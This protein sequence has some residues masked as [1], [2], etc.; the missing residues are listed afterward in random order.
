MGKQKFLPTHQIKQRVL[1]VIDGGKY[2]SAWE[3]GVAAYA[4][5]IV[6]EMES[7]SIDRGVMSGRSSLE[8][9]LL[10]GARDWHEFSECGCS[11]I[12]DRDIAERLCCPSELKR[13][14]YGDWRPNSRET[15]IDVQ[16]R[17][18]AQ[19]ARLA[20]KAFTTVAD[21]GVAVGPRYPLEGGASR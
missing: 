21:Q 19:A 8:A 14:R 7:T 5:E 11:L 10:N 18:L 16:T 20:R 17:A 3:R 15:W 12:Y 9:L 13:R 1:A 2:R 4:H 6:S